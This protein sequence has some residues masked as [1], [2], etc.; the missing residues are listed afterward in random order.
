MKKKSVLS[1]LL[2][3]VMLLS[4]ACSGGAAEQQTTEQVAEEPTSQP[5][6]SIDADWVISSSASEGPGSLKDAVSQAVSGD[7][8]AF[9]P[10][11]FDPYAPVVIYLTEP[12][13]LGVGGIT[14]DASN[15]GVILDGS[16]GPETAFNIQ[17]S[18]NVI[19]GLKITNFSL[20]G[21]VVDGE[22]NPEEAM[23]NIIGGDHATGVGPYGQGNCLVANGDGIS[24]QRGASENTITGNLIGM[25]ADDSSNGNQ[26]NG[27]IIQADAHRNVIGPRNNI[28]N[29][30]QTGVMIYGGSRGNTI[31]QT[32][33]FNNGNGNVL[34]QNGGNYELELLINQIESIDKEQGHISAWINLNG[35][36]VSIEIYSGDGSGP[37]FFEGEVGEIEPGENGDYHINFSKESPFNGEYIYISGYDGEGNST[38]FS[39]AIDSGMVGASNPAGDNSITNCENQYEDAK[40]AISTVLN[41]PQVVWQETFDN[42]NQ[43]DHWYLEGDISV[44]NGMLV[45]PPSGFRPMN[46]TEAV[47]YYAAE[48]GF[49]G[50][51]QAVH[52]TLSFMGARNLMVGASYKGTDSYEEFG[53]G[54]GSTDQ[55]LV[56]FQ[57]SSDF[58]SPNPY[59]EVQASEGSYAAALLE[60]DEIFI[61][62][63]KIYE[64]LIVIDN[65]QQEF[66]AVMWEPCNFESALVARLQNDPKLSEL[67]SAGKP[68]GFSIYQSGGENT[69]TVDNIEYIAYEGLLQP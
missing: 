17:S 2:L 69:V 32:A 12:L 31:T 1:I 46:S 28:A 36:N 30:G 50:G 15:V 13:F 53:F 37:R 44:E 7:V 43:M 67:T 40:Q 19:Q 4:A 23:H 62:E 39:E 56:N 52:V 64:V 8:I 18:D 26:S 14:I 21:I 33:V 48:S 58:P 42:M 29:N 65:Q 3:S 47:A 5:A 51:S 20:A 34:C 6:Q 27:I 24:I 59:I 45:L 11:T 66:V 60:G 54:G 41:N 49:E 61:E 68:W 55:I 63:N 25:E 57:P 22:G 10:S 38:M 16:M 9:D 35:E